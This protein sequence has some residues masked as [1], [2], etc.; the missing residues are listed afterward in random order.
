M[1][2]DYILCGLRVRSSLPFP[3]LWPWQGD[4]RSPDVE[5]SFDAIQEPTEPPIFIRTFSKLWADG[6]YILGLDNV[7]RFCV[8]SGRRI[9]ANPTSGALESELRLFI[10]GTCFGVLC[11]QRGLYPLHA[12]AVNINGG[13]VLFAGDSGKGKS[14]IA[15]ALGARGHA[16]LA[17]DV[18]VVDSDFPHLRPSYPQ[19]KLSPDVMEALGLIH[20]EGQELIRPGTI[21]L[22]VPAAGDF[23]PSP[24]PL[25][26]IYIIAGGMPNKLGKPEKL[27]VLSALTAL[28]AQMYRQAS[29]VRIQ[30][31]HALFKSITRIAQAS[32]VYLLPLGKGYP[33]SELDALAEFLETHAGTREES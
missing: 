13:A 27:D 24:L 1:S 9:Q 18:S 19:R 21:K 31:E 30:T 25:S 6:T 16:L 23:S 5:I 28:R 17:D 4:D 8:E 22:R 11:H 33:L 2:S 14:T 29:G 26:A 12:S 10:L 15:A 32:P 20:N 7:G 3:E